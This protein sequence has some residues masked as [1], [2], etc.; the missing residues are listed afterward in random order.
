LPLDDEWKLEDRK[1]AETEWRLDPSRERKLAIGG[2][3]DIGSL[4]KSCFLFMRCAPEDI[5]NS[6][7]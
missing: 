2:N 3:E 1:A 6:L 7:N 5:I 4:Y